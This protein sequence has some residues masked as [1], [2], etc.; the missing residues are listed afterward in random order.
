MQVSR[1]GPSVIFCDCLIEY[2]LS[3]V[4]LYTGSLSAVRA[5]SGVTSAD[6]GYSGE[7]SA[8][9]RHMPIMCPNSVT[10]SG[11]KGGFKVC[12]LL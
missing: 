12:F 7:T 10:V 3:Y 6:H 1:F 11:K 2:E 4:A 9:H 8:D 5:H